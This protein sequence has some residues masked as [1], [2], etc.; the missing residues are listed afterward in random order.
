MMV[1]LIIAILIVMVITTKISIE[2]SAIIT[3][4]TEFVIMS[5]RLIVTQYLFRSK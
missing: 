5:V 3:N 2:S 1:T 4:N